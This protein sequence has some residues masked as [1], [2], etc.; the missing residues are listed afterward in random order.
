MEIR[1]MIRKA[2][3][4]AEKVVVSR[5]CFGLPTVSKVANMIVTAVRTNVKDGQI[6]VDVEYVHMSNMR[7]VADFVVRLDRETFEVVSVERKGVRE[8]VK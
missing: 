7:D 3:R 5:I 2:N 8:G 1:E 6:K 4:K